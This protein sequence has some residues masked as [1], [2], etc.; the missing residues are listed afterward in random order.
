MNRYGGFERQVLEKYDTE[1]LALFREVFQ[2]LPL[3]AVVGR[4]PG[5]SKG[6]IFVTHGGIGPCAASMTLDELRNFKRF[7]EPFDDQ[8]EGKDEDNVRD[9]ADGVSGSGDPLAELLWCDPGVP[10]GNDRFGTNRPRG[11]GHGFTFGPEATRDFL[12]LN[13]LDLIVRSH[14]VCEAGV[15]LEHEG[16]VTVFSAPNYCDVVG[17]QGA[18]LRVKRGEGSTG[19]LDVRALVFDAVAHPRDKRRARG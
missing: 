10:P 17:N 6:G 18:V 9:T 15:R 11:L 5:Q 12:E 1:V 7:R 8:G 19:G 16:C 2:A 4:E 3:C 14:Q 13:G